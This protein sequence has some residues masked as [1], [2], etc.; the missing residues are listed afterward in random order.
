MPSRP[1]AANATVID[2]LALLDGPFAPL[3]EGVSQDRYALWLG[4]GI[5]LGRVE[6]LRKLIPHVL[7]FLQVRVTVGD[8][9]C[10]F[11]MALSAIF[12]TASLTPGERASID[13]EKP[14]EEWPG[15][16]SIID[17]LASNYARFLETAV[18]DEEDDYL[19][20]EA[21]AVTQTYGDPAIEPDVEHL[22]VAILIL[23]GLASDIPSANWDGLIERAVDRLALGVPTLVVCVHSDDLREPDLQARLYKFHGC[24]VR[25]RTDE[26]RFRPLLVARQ[27]QIHGWISRPEN[28]PLVARL[29]DI[30]TSKPTLMVGLSAQDANIQAIFAEAE[31]RMAWPWPSNPPAYAFSADQL[32]IDQRGLLKNVYRAAYNGA[33]RQQIY[34]SALIRA[35]A[36]SLLVALVLHV[37]CLKL[38]TLINLAPGNLQAAHR[39][40]IFL[41]ILRLRDAIARATQP[42]DEATVR[43]A[44]AHSARIGAMFH[45][46]DATGA[47]LPYRPLTSRAIQHMPSDHTLAGTGLREFAVALGLLG[48]GLHAGHWTI[49]TVNLDDSGAGALRIVS[50]AG[51]AKLFLA[52]SA[53]AAL[54]L[55]INGHVADVDNAIVINS[56]EIAVPMARSPR[57]RMGRKGRPGVRE[58]SMLK[59]LEEVSNGTELL[60][61]FREELIV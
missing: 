7:D 30:A 20:W 34:D 26:A 14:I 54:R 36:K 55:K 15:L 6:G 33:T 24:A 11:R 2:A 1:S 8:A 28:A 31:A 23:E 51:A 56:Q 4:S 18:N 39:A 35:Y 38:R 3:A 42:N 59:L 19:L 46:G 57:G 25:A 45:D 50:A 17:R 27:S 43:T 52:S 32:G 10:P 22:C 13:V 21:V 12:A 49:E 48:L 9:N 40:A 53:H 44:I 37:L 58:V 29:I 61:R 41:G 47:P 16:G 60:D 5:S